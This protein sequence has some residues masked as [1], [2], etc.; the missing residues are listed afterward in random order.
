MI[1]INPQFDRVSKLGDFSRYV[2][3]SVPIGLAILAGY[4]QSKG[5]TVKILDEQ[6]K[7]VSEELLREYVRDL[8][9]PYIFGISCF[10]AG[11]GRGYEIAKIV[12]SKYPE[13]K[14]VMGGIH[15]TVLPE[16]V[17]N[18]GDVDI[19]V[20]REGDETLNLL[21]DLIKKGE[22]YSQLLGISFKN[23]E[24]QIIHNSDAPLFSDINLL[25]PFPYHLFEDHRDK[26]NFGF[27]F[28]SRGCPYNCI[29][30][31]QRSISG[32]NYRYLSSPRVVAEIDL[33]VNKYG[34]KY[35]SFF[36][37]NFVVD[38]NRTKE[39]CQLIRERNFP[40]DVIFDCQ[41]RG[42]AVNEDILQ[43]LKSAGFKSIFFGLETASERL[44]KLINKG[45]TVKQNFAGV[46]LAKKIGF[47]VS[48]AFILG[49]PTETREERRQAYK[50]AK[51]LS[52]DN[53][54]FNN[55]TPYPGTEL[56]NIAIK[57]GRFNPGK[58]W[59]NLSACG[60]FVESPFKSS[61]LSYC[62]L[63][64][65]EKELRR[66]IAR[67]NLFFWFSPVRICR[68]L[69][70]GNVGGGWLSLPNKWYLKPKEWYYLS[71]MGLRLFLSLI[72]SFI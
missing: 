39:L 35:I 59:E 11:I 67:A 60:T 50:M 46:K 36:D 27:I 63:T 70:S 64:T 49:L 13:A 61:P 9:P 48:A 45:E 44:M 1:L 56:Y 52:L 72:K 40:K 8:K 16:E 65:T 69:T 14:V 12:K 20:R 33:L 43:E 47:Q 62:P 42:D 32:G 24:G 3:I 31:S 15:P 7:P 18:S 25:P 34:Q 2:P 66:D 54:R 53:V 57:E 5:K 38:K 6:I 58:N 22:D 28:S 10:T 30:C 4:L 17:L 26:Y 71:K 55:A 51:E 29:F 21:Y 41:T 19:V 68:I 37:D 23:K